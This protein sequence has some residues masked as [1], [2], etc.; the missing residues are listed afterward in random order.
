MARRAIFTVLLIVTGLDI[1]YAA[2]ESM[3][4]LVI[5]TW[6]FTDATQK[7]KLRPYFPALLCYY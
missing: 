4:P 7:G 6:P 1:V 3:L 5:N 2:H